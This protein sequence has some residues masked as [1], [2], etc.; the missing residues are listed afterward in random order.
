MKTVSAERRGAMRRLHARRLR[1]KPH[2][3]CF[4]ELVG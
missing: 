4:S 3:C 2:N 1:D